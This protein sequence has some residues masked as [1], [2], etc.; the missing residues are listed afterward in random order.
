MYKQNKRKLVAAKQ[1]VARANA[2]LA[3]RSKKSQTGTTMSTPISRGGFQP[4]TGRLPFYRQSELKCVDTPVTAFALN[5]TGSLVVLNVPQQGAAFYNRVGNEIEMKSVHITGLITPTGNTTG[6]TFEYGRIM[7]IY[8]FQPN[9]AYPTVADI[10][11]SYA[12]GGTV[13]STS[14]DHLNPNNF[15]RFKVLMDIRIDVPQ[16]ST[17]QTLIDTS[18]IIDYTK[19]EVNVNRFV[20]LRGMGTKF[21]AST[22]AIGDISS[23]SLFLF[24]LGSIAAGGEIYKAELSARLRFVD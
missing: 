6:G 1:A 14:F 3:A 20:N 8:D 10:L 7:L 9:G 13:T 19:N 18:N 11:S 21:K 22:G 23:G 15:A 2:I 16:N 5:T 17:T 24:T 12:T 4:Y